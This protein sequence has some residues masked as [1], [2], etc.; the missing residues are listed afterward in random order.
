MISDESHPE[1][2]KAY[3]ELLHRLGIVLGN[4]TNELTKP[5]LDRMFGIVLDHRSQCRVRGIDFPV[6]VALVVPRLGIIEFKRADLDIASLRVNIVN[7]VRQ[8]P[9]ATMDEVVGAFRSA[10]P[11]LKPDDILWGHDTGVKASERQAS[12]IQKVIDESTDKESDDK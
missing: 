7:F 12:R 11:D 10:Y 8:H 3:R 4:G 6:L 1:M 5:F 2:I 9:R